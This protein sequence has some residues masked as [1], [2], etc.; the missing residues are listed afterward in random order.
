MSFRFVTIVTVL[1]SI[2][3][4][5]SPTAMATPHVSAVAALIWS[6]YP[7]K[8]AKE[9]R[10][11]MLATAEDLGDSG[12]DDY[13]GYGL[14]QAAAARDFLASG[15]TFPD[16]PTEPDPTPPD[17]DC[18]D[19]IDWTDLWGDGCEWYKWIYRCLAFGSYAGSDGRTAFDACC[20][21]G[22]PAASVD[23]VTPTSAAPKVTTLT[24]VIALSL[25]TITG[26]MIQ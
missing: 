18:I 19:D 20:F 25:F 5:F 14:V 10:G 15:D 6:L 26:S 17:D 11:A 16:E 9:V 2:S 13:Y 7:D 22:G 1:N 23:A 21:C 24:V 3:L 4:L 12:R 8:T